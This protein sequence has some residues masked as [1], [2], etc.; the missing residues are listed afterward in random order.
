LSLESAKKLGLT[1]S[2]INILLPV[3][4]VT[5][6]AGYIIFVFSTL[7]SGFSNN[8]T[9]LTAFSSVLSVAFFAFAGLGLIGFILFLI[10]LHNLSGYYSEPSIFRNVLLAYVLEIVAVVVA[11]I[12]LIAAIFSSALSALNSS[13]TSSFSSAILGL[14][15]A[16]G[17]FYI[18]SIIS[19]VFFMRAFNRL[20]EKSGV[21][22]FRTFG[23]LYLIG[24]LLS[25]AVIGAVITWVGWIFGASGF[26]RLQPAAPVNPP[27]Q[28]VAAPTFT[29]APVIQKRF[30]GNCGSENTIDAIYCGSCGKPLQ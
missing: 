10:A 17:A 5:V 26:Q 15:G 28:T 13:F 18:L 27:P 8:L 25:P 3:I 16:A 11:A 19:A 29:A 30:C 22:S 2:L 23:L 24:I 4:M 7:T 12:V 9:G 21:D 14:I 20:A 6:Y 1:A